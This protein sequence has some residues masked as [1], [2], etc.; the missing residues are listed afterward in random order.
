MST[1]VYAPNVRTRVWEP[2]SL[3]DGQGVNICPESDARLRWIADHRHRCG[4]RVGD[5]VDEWDVQSPK[6]FTNQ[7]GGFE[8]FKRNFRDLMEPMAHTDRELKN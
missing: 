5:A 4:G 7:R 2:R 6:L 8:F 1:R 3:N